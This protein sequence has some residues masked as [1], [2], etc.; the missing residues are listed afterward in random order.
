VPDPDFAAWGLLRSL[1]DACMRLKL[2]L[3]AQPPIITIQQQAALDQWDRELERIGAAL[4][5]RDN[6]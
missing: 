1:Y 4:K 2:N 6:A 5:E 3:G